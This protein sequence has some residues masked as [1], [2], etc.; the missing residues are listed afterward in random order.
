[1]KCSMATRFMAYLLLAVPMTAASGALAASPPFTG[2]LPVF[3]TGD[4]PAGSYVGGVQFDL[5]IPAGVTVTNV[6]NKSDQGSMVAFN[7]TT[8]TSVRVAV[9]NVASG[10]STLFLSVQCSGTFTGMVTT[11]FV[12]GNAQTFDTLGNALSG[13]TLTSSYNPDGD[14][15]ND[16]Q[17]KSADALVALRIAV[18]LTPLTAPALIHGDMNGDGS[19]TSAD[20]LLILRKA[21]GL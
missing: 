17:A 15:N 19:I 10:I 1:M 6:V 4:P 13:V 14:L 9:A 16:G 18:G 21:V 12:I 7:P 2:T 11:D 20:A 3:T 8:A 5:A